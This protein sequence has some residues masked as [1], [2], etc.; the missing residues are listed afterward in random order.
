MDQGTQQTRSHQKHLAEKILSFPTGHEIPFPIEL[1]I[2][3]KG[4]TLLPEIMGI[5]LVPGIPNELGLATCLQ[6]TN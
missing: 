6:Y 1:G 4:I 2:P 3:V 5:I